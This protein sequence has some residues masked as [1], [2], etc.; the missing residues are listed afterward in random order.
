MPWVSW[1][2]PGY[3]SDRQRSQVAVVQPQEKKGPVFSSRILLYL[4]QEQIN[5]IFKQRRLSVKLEIQMFRIRNIVA[6]GAGLFCSRPRCY[7]FL[8]NRQTPRISRPYQGVPWVCPVSKE[9]YFGC[10]PSD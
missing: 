7:D 10:W 5:G 8:S 3:C 2:Y 6:P 9:D 4:E 1:T